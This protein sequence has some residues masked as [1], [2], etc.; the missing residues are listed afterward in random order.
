METGRGPPT[1]NCSPQLR[2]ESRSILVDTGKINIL[3]WILNF[4]SSDMSGN[5][6][7]QNFIEYILS[8]PVYLVAII[9]L[10]AGLL[11]S[12]VKRLLKLVFALC[13]LILILGIVLYFS[14]ENDRVREVVAPVHEGIEEVNTFINN[15]SPQLLKKIKQASDSLLVSTDSTS[16]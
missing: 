13:V 1:R 15:K 16:P 7:V 8:N 6:D 12:L 10:A 3:V 5:K 11:V 9:V 14:S 4:V 2:N